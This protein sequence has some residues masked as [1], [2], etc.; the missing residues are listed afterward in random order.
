[1]EELEEL[2]YKLNEVIEVTSAIKNPN[3]LILKDI[4]TLKV[5]ILNNL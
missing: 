1:M 4:I 5:K 3:N 2:T